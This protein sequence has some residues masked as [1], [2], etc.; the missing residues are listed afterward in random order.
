MSAL[1][2]V[3]VPVQ[4]CQL[5]AAQIGMASRDAFYLH[6]EAAKAY[7]VAYDYFFE[8]G[9]LLIA[10]DGYRPLG[11][12]TILYDYYAK[13]LDFTKSP[14]G[15]THPKGLSVD[16]TLWR[17]NIELEFQTSIA[18]WGPDSYSDRISGVS[19]EALR[20]RAFL[21]EG[22]LKAGFVSHQAEWWHFDYQ[23]TILCEALDERP[24]GVPGHEHDADIKEIVESLL[25]SKK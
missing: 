10:V 1:V 12:Q 9:Y 6:K 15:S 14:V 16:V 2:K 20:N 19:R 5:I 17:D 3:N 4:T 11:I 22:M 7:E 18:T 23:T 8:L 21:Q 13:E 25:T 24:E